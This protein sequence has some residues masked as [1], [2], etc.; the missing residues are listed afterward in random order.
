MPL[1]RGCSVL[2]DTLQWSSRP[3]NPVTDC[4]RSLSS[5]DYAG[6]RRRSHAVRREIYF[7]GLA[8][9]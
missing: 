1:C 2:T 3:K 5:A 7:R 8:L 9:A 4:P 6:N